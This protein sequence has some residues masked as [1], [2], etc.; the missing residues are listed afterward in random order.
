MRNKRWAKRITAIALAL[1]S[2]VGVA[3]FNATPAYAGVYG[4]IINN[5]PSQYPVK[6]AKFGVGGSHY[7]NTIN[8]GSL[9]CNEWWL[10][11]GQSDTSLKGYWFDTDGFKVEN[12]GHYYVSGYGWVPDYMWFRIQDYHEVNCYMSNGSPY[13]A[14]Y[15]F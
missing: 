15:V 11:S 4:D 9:T 7:C 8:S 13:C 1:M 10:P 12:S 6:I 2:M 5:L 14:V 3:L